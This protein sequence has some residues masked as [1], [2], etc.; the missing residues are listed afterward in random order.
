MKVSFHLIQVVH[1]STTEGFFSP[2]GKKTSMDVS[3]VF[4]TFDGYYI[5]LI[6]IIILTTAISI[7]LSFYFIYV[8]TIRISREFNDVESNGTVAFDALEKLITNTENLSEEILPDVCRSVYYI[9]GRWIGNAPPPNTGCLF[10][11]PISIC[12]DNIMPAQ[13]LPYINLLGCT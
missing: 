4:T 13:C 10:F 8:P 7:A 2:M 6:I 12:V 11:L 9:L 1:V 5:V 3:S